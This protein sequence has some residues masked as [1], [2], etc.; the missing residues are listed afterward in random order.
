MAI[1]DNGTVAAAVPIAVPMT[2]LVNGIKKTTNN[3][4]GKER[5]IL[6]NKFK[7]EKTNWFSST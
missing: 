7:I 4:N 2:N 1:I 5:I 6:T 3:K